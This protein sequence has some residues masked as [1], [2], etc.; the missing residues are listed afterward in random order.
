MRCLKRKL[1]DSLFRALVADL[2]DRLAEQPDT[3]AGTS[4]QRPGDSVTR[5]F[6]GGPGRTVG[7]D[8]AIQRDWPNPGSQL[9]GQVTS[10]THRAGRY[11]SHRL[12]VSTR[13]TRGEPL[14]GAN[15]PA[16][17]YGPDAD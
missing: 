1:S 14:P 2:N 11:A 5:V 17:A 12:D 7:G 4:T 10:R 15:A 13:L 6:D 3:A 8:S 16:G 9:F